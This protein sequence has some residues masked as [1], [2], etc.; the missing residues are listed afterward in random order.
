MIAP[1]LPTVSLMQRIDKPKA[2]FADPTPALIAVINRYFEPEP[3]ILLAQYGPSVDT[4][5]KA[6]D[7]LFLPPDKVHFKELN[8]PALLIVFQLNLSLFNSVSVGTR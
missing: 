8:A 2:L 3:N 7:V 4:V 6:P 1:T 5:T